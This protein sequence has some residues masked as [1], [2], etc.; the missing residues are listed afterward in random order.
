MA[1]QNGKR[2][3]ECSLIQYRVVSKYILIGLSTPL[4]YLHGYKSYIPVFACFIIYPLLN[5]PGTHK[6]VLADSTLGRSAKPRVKPSKQHHIHPQPQR[7]GTRVRAQRCALQHL[8]GLRRDYRCKCY[9]TKIIAKR[10]IRMRGQA[11]LIFKDINSAMEA[12]RNFN[13]RELYGKTMVRVNSTRKYNLL[14]RSLTSLLN[15]MALS[16]SGRSLRTTSK[17]NFR[18]SLS[19]VPSKSRHAW[20]GRRTSSKN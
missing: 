13:G 19:T 5:E 6:P 7:K 20:S 17:S 2:I 16:R 4:L 8:R 9:V 14:R 12:R 18:R 1:P 11:F 15:S 3:S 10:N